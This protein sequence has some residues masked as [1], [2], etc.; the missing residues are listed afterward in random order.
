M[1]EKFPPRAVGVEHAPAVPKVHAPERMRSITGSKRMRMP[2][3]WTG[4]GGC[5]HS[6]LPMHIM[7][8]HALPA[9][10][11]TRRSTVSALAGAVR[12]VLNAGPASSPID[13]QVDSDG[14]D[15]CCAE[16]S[17]DQRE[18]LPGYESISYKLS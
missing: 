12:I 1:E 17:R 4:Q 11:S 14:Y 18:S 13:P 2:R 5:R 6:P 10:L 3:Q 7:L 15:G 9:R 8:M 16:V